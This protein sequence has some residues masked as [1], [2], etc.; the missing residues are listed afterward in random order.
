MSREQHRVAWNGKFSRVSKIA[1]RICL[2][3]RSS[4][5]LLYNFRLHNASSRFLPVFGY[6]R[7]QTDG[8]LGRGGG[9][10][11][12][13]VHA[14]AKWQGTVGP[15]QSRAGPVYSVCLKHRSREVGVTA[16]RPH[17]VKAFR[18]D[19]SNL[20]FTT[21]FCACVSIAFLTLWRRN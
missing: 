3:S 21:K 1:S 9:G 11:E 10:C 20:S 17:C 5:Q 4:R 18:T 15:P 7:R 8:Y 19:S 12:G 2:W 13:R 14:A 6:T 16:K